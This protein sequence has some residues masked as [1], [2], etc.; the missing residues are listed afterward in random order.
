MSQAATIKIEKRL[1]TGSGVS[2][3]LRR[4]GYLPGCLYGRELEPINVRVREDE[5]RRNMTRYGRNHLYRLAMEG[6][7]EYTVIVKDLQYSPTKGNVLNVDF[8]QISLTEEMRADIEIRITGSKVLESKRLLLIQ[9]IDIIPVK[10]LPQDI[11]NGI[12][13]DV[14]ELED[15]ETLCIGDIDFPKGIEATI[16]DDQVVLSV[17]VPEM[18]TEDDDSEVE[19]EVTEPTEETE[20]SSDGSQA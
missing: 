14:S 5:L 9:Q 11:P 20:Q 17:K 7:E 1:K 19:D 12:T 10:G 6:G 13:V 15:G 4:E 8:Q 16:E 3:Q 2:R 18:D